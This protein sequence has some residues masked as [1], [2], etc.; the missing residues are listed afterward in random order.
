MQMV[1]ESQGIVMEFLGSNYLLNVSQVMVKDKTGTLAS[2]MRGR[3]MPTTAF[4]FNAAPGSGIAIGGQRNIAAP[5]LFKV[6]FPPA[7]HCSSPELGTPACQF[8]HA[9]TNAQ[10]SML[11]P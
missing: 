7:M 1:T 3:L 10:G 6:G 9:M 11:R 5:K 4:V 2:G 8:W